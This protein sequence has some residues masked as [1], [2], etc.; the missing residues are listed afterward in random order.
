MDGWLLCVYKLACGIRILLDLSSYA[1]LECRLPIWT[2]HDLVG[3]W[4]VDCWQY[5]ERRV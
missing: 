4:F 1:Y 5:A 2:V 3:V